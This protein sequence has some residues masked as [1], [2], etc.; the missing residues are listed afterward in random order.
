MLR[1]RCG[2]ER[3][4]TGGIVDIEVGSVNVEKREDV[5]ELLEKTPD[6]SVS[7]SRVVKQ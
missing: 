7:V 1:A 2:Q 6:V 5:V 3:R 4:H